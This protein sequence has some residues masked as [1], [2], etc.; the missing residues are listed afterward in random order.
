[1]ITEKFLKTTALFLITLLAGPGQ[2]T[3]YPLDGYE[4]TGDPCGSTWTGCCR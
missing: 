1:M 3:A 2:L 4:E